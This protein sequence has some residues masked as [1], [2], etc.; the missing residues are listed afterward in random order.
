L[1]GGQ[2][3][4]LCLCQFVHLSLSDWRDNAVGAAD[5]RALTGY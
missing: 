1:F 2:Q 4:A 5:V 3:L